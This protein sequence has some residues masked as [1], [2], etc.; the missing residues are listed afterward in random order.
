MGDRLDQRLPVWQMEWS[1]CPERMMAQ[2]CL[3]G[4]EHCIC[5]NRAKR[6]TLRRMNN[7]AMTKHKLA[8]DPESTAIMRNGRQIR[9]SA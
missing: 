5:S 2:P 6:Q 9:P 7:L 3:P 8:T 1:K 4:A